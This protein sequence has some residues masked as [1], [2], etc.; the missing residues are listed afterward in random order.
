[1]TIGFTCCIIISL[2]VFHEFSYDKFNKD[3]DRIFRVCY[4]V[5]EKNVAYNHYLH[6]KELSKQI[7]SEIP[8]I[9]K[10]AAYKWAW[11]TTIKYNGQYYSELLAL[12]EPDFFSIFSYRLIS[13]NPAMLL[14]SP[15]DLIITED[16]A[17][18]LSPSGS[19]NYNDLIGK[20]V[21]FPNNLRGKVF[22]ISGILETLPST[23][24][25]AFN[26]LIPLD[27]QDNFSQSN[28]DFGNTSVYIKLKE[29][30]DINQISKTASS[31]ILSF[32]ESKIKELQGKNVLPNSSD[33]FVPIFQPLLKVYLDSSFDNDYVKQGNKTNLYILLG[34]GLL[35][36]F[37]GCCNFILL[38]LGQFL[39]KT[40][41]VGVQKVFGAKNWNIFKYFFAEVNVLAFLA[42]IAGLIISND[43]LPLYSRFA[44]I[45][46]TNKLFYYPDIFLI[47]GLIYLIIVTIN[48]IVPIFVFSKIKP[49]SLLKKM[50]LKRG[51]VKLPF[52]FVT[53]QYSISM[54]L[55]ISSLFIYSQVN[56]MK[57]KN[58]GFTS[59][60]VLCVE[61]A[62]MPSKQRLTFRDLLKNHPGI[63]NVTATNMD[64]VN[65]RSSNYMKKENGENVG[66]RFIRADE[67]YIQTLGLQL[68]AGENFTAGNKNDNDKNIIV[69]EKFI[70]SLDIKDDPVGKMIQSPDLPF[71][72]NILGVVKDFHFDSMKEDLQPL[73]LVANTRFESI[74]YLF[75][76]FNEKSIAEVLQFINKSWDEIVTDR[77]A[78][79]SFWDEKL[80]SRYQNEE[81]WSH[82]LN[83]ASI[84]SI[85]I[86][87]LGLFGLTLLIINNKTKE[88]GIRKVNGVK[89][90]EIVLMLNFNFV[91]WVAIAFVIACPVA[92]YAMHKWLQNF[93][94]RIEL[95]WWIFLLA[96]IIALGIALLTVSWQSWRAATRN[97]VE[98]LRYE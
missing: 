15:N 62:D 5:H 81:R 28:N 8:L 61:M 45:D 95:H 30:T 46:I 11:G 79:I 14:Q 98:A 92:W 93:A 33:C 41:K 19:R 16:F 10:S 40:K 4:H 63:I 57:Y 55:I 75:V 9:E 34:I 91:K 56:Y 27:Y 43:L 36:L 69:N 3:A 88:I 17:K 52:V 21:E 96:G 32:Y 26:M 83:Y 54:I 80:E 82:I 72:V 7:K 73:A 67:N 53:L 37:V 35:I 70:T 50:N 44:Q 77:K 60:N 85:F 86:T 24:S 2:H 20:T 64:F 94:Y 78:R 97:P 38:F 42:L 47:I 13:G 1:L 25:M 74:N 22:T 66:V 29:G 12:T 59:K 90:L 18:K 39:K 49:V 31:A 68:I 48:C 89:S 71:A 65:G 58:L 6:P 76:R 84:L 51:Q 87:T 23:S